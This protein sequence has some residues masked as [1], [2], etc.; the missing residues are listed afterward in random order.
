MIE[1]VVISRLLEYPDAALWQHQQELI[2]ALQS[3]THFT[4][5]QSRRYRFSA[6]VDLAGSAGCPGKLQRTV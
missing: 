1:L 4:A 6:A 5:S 2:E 3:S